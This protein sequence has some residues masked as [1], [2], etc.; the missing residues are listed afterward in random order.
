[1][2]GPLGPAFNG[3]NGAIENVSCDLSAFAGSTVVIALRIVTDGS[4]FL[5]GIWVDD[6]VLAGTSLS[7][8]TTLDGWSSPTQY[9]PIEVESYTVR[10]VASRQGKRAWIAEVPL[11]ADFSGTLRGGKLRKAIGT[12]AELVAAIVTYHDSTETISQYAP[13]MLLVNGVQQPGG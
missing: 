9:N 12:Q 6:V 2:E 3:E 8:G 1:V 7:D 5:D 11:D 13:Y 10:L 4:F